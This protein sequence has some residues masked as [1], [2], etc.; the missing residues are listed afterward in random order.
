MPLYSLDYLCAAYLDQ[1]LEHD[2]A[3]SR[4]QI[5][6]DEIRRMKWREEKRSR[7]AARH[8]VLMSGL[9]IDRRGETD[10]D[11]PSFI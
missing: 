9:E 10:T 11:L 7:R 6:Y 5:I 1:G 2:E 8:E 4:A 3:L